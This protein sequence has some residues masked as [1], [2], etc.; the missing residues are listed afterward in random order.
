[1]R[2]A[3]I[4]MFDRL[5]LGGLAL[6]LVNTAIAYNSTMEQLQAD[7]A[8]AELGLA[9]PGFF[10]G[11]AAF[12]YGIS[13][14]LWF[15]ISRKANNVAKWILTV[16]TVIGALMVPL[17]LGELDLFASIVTVIAT[18]LQV[19][20]VWMLFRPDAKSWFEHGPGGM[21]PATFE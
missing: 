8:V 11:S 5:F 20:A 19:A 15:L 18:V 10:I 2:P 17:S 13:L 12:G 21:D 4:T 9:T 3:S 14:L 6:G 1:M 7:P 16:L